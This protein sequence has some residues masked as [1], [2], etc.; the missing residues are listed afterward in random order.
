MVSVDIVDPGLYGPDFD[1]DGNADL[2][3]SQVRIDYN[4]TITFLDAN[5]NPVSKDLNTSDHDGDGYAD[6]SGANVSTHGTYTITHT[7]LNHDSIMDYSAIF[8]ELGV[9]SETPVLEYHDQR[10]LNGWVM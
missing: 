4:S 9:F 7:L 8:T 1:T 3:V 2:N 5:G 6:F 10:N